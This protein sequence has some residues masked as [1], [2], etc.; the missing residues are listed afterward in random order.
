M[1]QSSRRRKGKT[2]QNIIRDKILKNFKHLKPRDVMVADTGQNGPDIILSK[3]GLKLIEHT[4]EAK[5]QN[6]CQTV[7]KWFDQA[8]KHSKAY[9][10]P[11]LVIKANT[12]K[13]LAVIDLDHLFELIKE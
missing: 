9:C 2:L 1:L 5:N 7:Y 6:R 4:W 8:K 11:V 3:V 12:R 13:P 10:D